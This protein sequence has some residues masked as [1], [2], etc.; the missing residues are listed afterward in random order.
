MKRF[1]GTLPLWIIGTVVVVIGLI[2]VTKLMPQLLIFFK[3]GGIAA[4]TGAFIFAFI[5]NAKYEKSLKDEEE[6]KE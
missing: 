3:I 1:K 2:Y 6:R 5:D 4:F